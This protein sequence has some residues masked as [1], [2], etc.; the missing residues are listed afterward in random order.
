MQ[1]IIRH[2]NHIQNYATSAGTKIKSIA[3]ILL[4]LKFEMTDFQL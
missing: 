3:L 1:L 2:D 4:Y